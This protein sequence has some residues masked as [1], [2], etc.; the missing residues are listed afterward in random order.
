MPEQ[1][2]ELESLLKSLAGTPE[3][4]PQDIA[5]GRAKLA[6]EMASGRRSKG[7]QWLRLVGVGAVVLAIAAGVVVAGPW[8]TTPVEATI[9]EILRAA[10]PIDPSLV[11][12][13]QFVLIE[14]K[15]LSLAVVP[16]EGLGEVEFDRDELVYVL[17]RRR[18]MWVGNQGTTRITTETS[19]PVF[20]RESDE[21]VYYTAGLDQEDLVGETET[22]TV[23]G[24]TDRDWPEDR[25]LLDAIIRDTLAADRGFDERFEYLEVLLRVFRSPWINAQTRYAAVELIGEVDDLQIVSGRDEFATFAIEYMDRGVPTIRTFSIDDNGY[26]RFDESRYIAPNEEFGV[27]AGTAFTSI[28]YTAPTIVDALSED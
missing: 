26:L 10:E 11:S 2:I 6:E 12:D 20:F 5:K 1:P 14:S 22:I 18:S 19:G 28:T 16:A 17:P 3:P 4:T 15:E 23:Q 8:Q 7:I 9:S 27:P 13:D 25:D 24:A 21:D